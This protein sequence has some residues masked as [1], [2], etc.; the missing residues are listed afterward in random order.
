MFL[1]PSRRVTANQL[2]KQ[3]TLNRWFSRPNVRKTSRTSTYSWRISWV[4]ARL[5]REPNAKHHGRKYRGMGGGYNL[6]HY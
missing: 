4:D 6:R 1:K 3:R 2:L 5:L